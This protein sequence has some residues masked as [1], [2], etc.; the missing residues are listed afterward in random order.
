MIKSSYL[1]VILLAFCSNMLFAQHAPAWGGGADQSDISFGFSFS[2]VSSYLKINKD[3]NWQT[4][5]P[6]PETGAPLTPALTAIS[7][8]NSSGFAVGFITRYRIT[9]H[10]EA[11]TTPSLVF[12][13]RMLNYTYATDDPQLRSVDKKITTTTVDVPLLLKIKSDRLGDYRGYLIGGVKFSGA[14]GSKKNNDN[15]DLTERLVRNKGFFTSYEAGIGC[16][17]YFEYFKLSP[18]IKISNSIGNILLKENHPY[19]TPLSSLSLHTIE[20]SLHFE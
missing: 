19:S 4:P 12:A 17:I 18:E 6:D 3:P 1:T 14:I 2:Y 9:D 10:L 15:L 13:D 8:K 11:R 16:D 20:F 7:S 5:F